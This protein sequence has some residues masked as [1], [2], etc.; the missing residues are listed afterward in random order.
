[1]FGSK[2]TKAS[3]GKGCQSPS[4]VYKY[5]RGRVGYFIYTSDGD[6]RTLHCWK[7]R[8]AKIINHTGVTINTTLFNKSKCIFNT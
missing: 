1:M 6:R 4:Q 7:F 2:R 5:V 8:I 3:L